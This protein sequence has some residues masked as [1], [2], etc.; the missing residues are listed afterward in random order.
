MHN[1]IRDPAHA[2]TVTE[3]NARLFQV[4][5]ET[6]G[7]AIPLQPDRG[8]QLNLRRGDG[9]RA[10]DFPPALYVTQ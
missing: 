8:P 1:L 2:Q 3:M 4:L 5:E 9:P 7:L 6:D 10:A